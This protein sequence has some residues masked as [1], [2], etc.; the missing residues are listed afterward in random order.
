V[1]PFYEVIFSME[2]H[3]SNS[4]SSDFLIQLS[5]YSSRLSL[6]SLIYLLMV[7]SSLFNFFYT[8]WSIC[9][10]CYSTCLIDSLAFY[11]F[12]AKICNFCWLKLLLL[13]SLSSSKFN[14]Y[15]KLCVRKC[16]YRSISWFISCQRS[17]NIF[18]LDG[19]ELES[20]P[21]II[22]CYN[23]IIN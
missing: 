12:Y 7:S 14:C 15:Y 8:V 21:F 13:E 3:I 4:F 17:C 10:L 2:L 6:Y 22:E 18:I 19:G 16:F 9:Y 1:S 5:L 11:I 20:L 23:L